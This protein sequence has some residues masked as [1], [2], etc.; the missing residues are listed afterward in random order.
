AG[1]QLHEATPVEAVQVTGGRIRSIIVGS[2]AHAVDCLVIAAGTHSVAIAGLPPEARAPG[3]PIKGQMLALSMPP[4]AP[5]PR[6]VPWT[7]S[8]YLVPRRD[9]RLIVGATVEER[10]YDRSL[11]AGGIFALLEGAWRAL[12][13]IEELPIAAMWVGHRPGTPDDAP[14]I[15]KT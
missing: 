1:G 11:S 8:G 15:G 4:H 3:P 2:S 6:H 14:I 9:G 10:G 5:L 13:G 12:P 7:P